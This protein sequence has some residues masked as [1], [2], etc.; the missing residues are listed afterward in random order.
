MRDTY[1]TTNRFGIG[2][3]ALCFIKDGGD[4]SKKK[5]FLIKPC[6]VLLRNKLVH[7]GC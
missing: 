5:Q 7:S 1:A 4:I 3:K 6:V 2:Q